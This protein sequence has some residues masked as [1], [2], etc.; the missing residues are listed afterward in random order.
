VKLVRWW[1]WG[2]RPCF[3]V[4]GNTRAIDKCFMG[5]MILTLALSIFYQYGICTKRCLH[6]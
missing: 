6:P 1:C 2:K 5:F 3:K 4:N